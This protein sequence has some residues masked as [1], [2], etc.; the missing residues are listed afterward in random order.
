MQNVS[1]AKDTSCE[2]IHVN[3][4]RAREW[5]KPYPKKHNTDNN[6]RRSEAVSY[7]KQTTKK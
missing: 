5:K 7:E 1:L 2:S 6:E 3:S 4:K